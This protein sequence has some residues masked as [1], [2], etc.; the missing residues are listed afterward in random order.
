MGRARAGFTLIELIAVIA[1]V[2][3]LS[4]TAIPA[5]GRIARVHSA[6][7]AEEAANRLAAAR[8]Y[9][10]ATGSPAGVRFDLDRQ[11]M[12]FVLMVDGAIEQRASG[13]E[14]LGG[15]EA[16]RVATIGGGRLGGT[17]IRAANGR[18]SDTLWFDYEGVPHIRSLGGA[19]VAALDDPAMVMIADGPTVVVS[20]RTGHI[21]IDRED[22]GG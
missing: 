15:G 9:A 1:L 20:P 18:T 21:A 22:G 8:A 14:G 17:E 2:A 5:L 16:D 3:M 10:T 7:L 6:V 12:T 11:A 4:I 13:F 19:F